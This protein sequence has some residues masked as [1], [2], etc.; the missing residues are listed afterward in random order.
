MR[1]IIGT[2]GATLAV[3]AAIATPAAAQAGPGGADGGSLDNPRLLY[4]SASLS[5]ECFPVAVERRDAAGYIYYEYEYVCVDGLAT[6]AAAQVDNIGRST[7]VTLDAPFIGNKDTG[8]AATSPLIG[9]VDTYASDASENLRLN[10]DEGTLLVDFPASADEQ[11]SQFIDG[12]LNP[13]SVAAAQDPAATSTR[14][15]FFVF[16]SGPT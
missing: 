9:L 15:R 13:T 3:V 2:I 8:S 4:A 6:P 11:R 5:S 16:A 12:N 14:K 1:R 7:S 10:V